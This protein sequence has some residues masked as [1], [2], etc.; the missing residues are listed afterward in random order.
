MESWRALI[1]PIIEDS[2]EP[3]G[4]VAIVTSDPSPRTLNSSTIDIIG[5]A[6]LKARPLYSPSKMSAIPQL[7][8]PQGSHC[9]KLITFRMERSLSSVSFEVTESSISLENILIFLKPLS[10]LMSELK[11]SLLYI[12]FRS[13]PV[14]NWLLLSHTVCQRGQLQIPQ[15]SNL[16][17]DT[18]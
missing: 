9:L 1:T 13:T 4:F 5:T 7:C 16:C 3:N 17:I 6:A 14:M 12:K 10:I 11:S 15:M 18:S 8:H 2:S